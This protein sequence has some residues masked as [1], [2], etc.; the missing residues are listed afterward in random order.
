[1]RPYC[2]HHVDESQIV[3]IRKA[4]GFVAV[5]VVKG[6]KKTIFMHKARCCETE[7]EVIVR[8]FLQLTLEV[9]PT[10]DSKN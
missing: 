10:E 4:V 6:G 9:A 2:H 7:V 3:L 1:M 8:E 5:K